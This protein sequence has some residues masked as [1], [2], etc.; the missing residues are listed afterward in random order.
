[1]R[2]KS[3]GALTQSALIEEWLMKNDFEPVV[4]RKI[5]SLRIADAALERCDGLR[6]NCSRTVQATFL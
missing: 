6:G 1:M 5:Q 4:G 3:S 2:P